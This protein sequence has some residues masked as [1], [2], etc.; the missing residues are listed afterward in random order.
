MKRV[1]Y[2]YDNQIGVFNYAS[3][4]P[5]RPLRVKMTHALITNYGLFNHMDVYKPEHAS[6][7]N[8]TNYHSKDYVNFLQSVCQDNANEMDYDLCKFNVG[9]DCPIFQGLYDY[10]RITTGGSLAATLKLNSGE[11]DISINWSGGLHH[12]KKSEASGFCYVNDIVLA[13]L[14][15]LKYNERVLY[16]DIDVHHGDGVEEAFYTTDRVMTVSF[17]KYGDYF[18]GTGSLDDTGLLKGKNYAVNVPL[19][20][21]ITDRNY[22]Y[23][24]NPVINKVI[25]MYKPSV[26]VMQCGADSLIGDRLGCFNLSHVGHA[27]CLKHV[28]SFNIPMLVLGGGGYTIKNVSKAWAYETSVLLDVEIPEDLPFTEFHSH[29]GPDYKITVPTNQMR[30]FNTKKDIDSIIEKIHENLRNITGVPSVQLTEIPPS[31][32][33]EDSN[34]DMLW[35]DYAERN[36]I[37]YDEIQHDLNE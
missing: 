31:W 24:F 32:V 5:M 19:K 35:M 18:P 17:H 10:C 21:G 36:N 30:D 29:Y 2:F 25:E 26:I 6:Y 3:G 23:I 28:K 20:D 13:I 8:L 9:E 12:A 4:H 14:E 11:S 15:L 16:I 22:Q 37:P 7:K 27:S 34:D 33:D 1:A